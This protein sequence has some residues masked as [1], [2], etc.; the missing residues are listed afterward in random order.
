[1]RPELVGEVEYRAVTQDRRLRHTA[2]RG[3]RADKDPTRVTFS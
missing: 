1:V 3:L 2:W